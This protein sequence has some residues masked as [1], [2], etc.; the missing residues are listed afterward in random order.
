ML[1]LMIQLF[2][3]LRTTDPN[4]LVIQV[5]IIR[6]Q[7][8]VTICKS[9]IYGCHIKRACPHRLI[10]WA[11]NMIVIIAIRGS[12]M[13]QILSSWLDRLDKRL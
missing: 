8:V 11:E 13:D 10:N 7:Y 2:L 9:S 12:P 6:S 4:W 1:L 5:G 3:S